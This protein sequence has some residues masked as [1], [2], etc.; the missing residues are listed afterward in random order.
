MQVSTV[1]ETLRQREEA[2]MHALND[3]RISV[4]CYIHMLYGMESD[5][6]AA[7]AAV[8]RCQIPDWKGKAKHRYESARDEASLIMHG[9]GASLK[10]VQAC[11][12]AALAAINEQRIRLGIGLDLTG[13]Q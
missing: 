12:A 4:E 5:V 9:A 8:N 10:D 11:A 1:E 13:V 3:L 6:T 2:V 7:H